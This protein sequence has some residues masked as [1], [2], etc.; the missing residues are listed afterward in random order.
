MREH[1]WK[2]YSA[3]AAVVIALFLFTPVEGWAEMGWEL[4]IA[5]AAVGAIL[6][7]IRRNHPSGKLVWWLFA[8]GVFGNASGILVEYVDIELFGG[9]GFPSKADVFYLSLYPML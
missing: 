8:A 7:G 3:G 6:L 4:G 1:T 2:V 5:Y 9:D